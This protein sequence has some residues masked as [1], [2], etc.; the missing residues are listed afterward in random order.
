MCEKNC[1]NCHFFCVYGNHLYQGCW[2]VVVSQKERNQIITE[3]SFYFIQNLKADYRICLCCFKGVWD[4]KQ[5]IRIING[6]QGESQFTDEEKG[7]LKEMLWKTIIDTNRKAN[8]SR[9]NSCFYRK[10]EKGMLLPAAEELE[11][12]ETIQKEASADRKWVVIGIVIT[13]LTT[14]VAVMLANYLSNKAD[15]PVTIEKLK[16]E[17][18]TKD[19]KNVTVYWNVKND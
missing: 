7:K 1:L 11:K 8:N 17:A 6:K 10:F 14:L 5:F 16:S 13:A 9:A 4:E 3:K 15:Y 12:R 18:Q 19:F 2:Q